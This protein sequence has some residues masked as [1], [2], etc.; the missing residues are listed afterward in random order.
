MISS[1]VA[2][3][4]C[5]DASCTADGLNYLMTP[6]GRNL[7]RAVE[8]SGA[9]G[10]R[11]SVS[12]IAALRRNYPAPAVAC[13]IA[14]SLS[15]NKAQVGKFASGPIVA[16]D[17]WAVPEALE[18]A[19]SWRV[20]MYKA[21]KIAALACPRLIL[22]ICCGLGGDML[23]L[24]NIA[25]TLGIDISPVRAWMA[26]K[27][28]DQFKAKFPVLV[29]QADMAQLPML[30]SNDVFF[31][32]DPSRRSGGKR[33][34]DFS[35][36]HPGPDIILP[37]MRHFP[38]GA[39]KLSP[40]VDFASLPPGHLELISEDAVVVQALLWTGKVGSMLGLR[41]RTATVI[42]GSKIWS[43]CEFASDV[44]TQRQIALAPEHWLY[45]VDGAV[46]RA[47]L[48]AP[49]ASQLNLKLLSPDGGYLTGEHYLDHPALTAFEVY[50]AMPYSESQIVR[51]IKNT[52]AT[53]DLTLPALTIKTRGGLGLDT[54][55]I[56][57]RLSKYGGHGWTVLIYRGGSGKIGVIARR[58]AS[59][60][61]DDHDPAAVV[62]LGVMR[63][64]RDENTR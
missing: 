52:A 49:L 5:D 44:A 42:G 62:E 50:C 32:L 18:Q 22:D 25:P 9:H 47:G 28:A 40:A 11:L 43:F 24:A 39:I 58:R 37:F 20:A 56:Q 36:M 8:L 29:I 4:R 26:R 13:A 21:N 54:D 60:P 33:R 57:Q 35:A 10:G 45:E 23:A 17:L 19:T 7:L 61:S 12:E 38:D 1:D 46:T 53:S 3:Y 14:V 34:A 55:N 30:P 16:H 15:R 41:Q 48:A 27:N 31:H 6:S 51:W 2:A 64:Q 59:P 63:K